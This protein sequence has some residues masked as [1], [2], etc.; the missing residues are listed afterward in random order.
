MEE[1]QRNA[2]ELYELSEAMAAGNIGHFAPGSGPRKLTLL[3]S[4]DMSSIK[5]QMVKTEEAIDDLQPAVSRQ[6]YA[7]P[8]PYEESHSKGGDEDD[9]DDDLYF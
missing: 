8:D 5:R 9:Y 4:H 7:L 6:A 2:D 3:E 1:R